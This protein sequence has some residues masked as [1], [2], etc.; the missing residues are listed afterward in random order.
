MRRILH[1]DQKANA[2]PQRRGPAGSFP[3]TV[4]FEKRTWTDVEPGKYLFSDYEVSKKVMYLLRHS[5]HVHREDDGA[6]QFWRIKE[7]LQKYYP[8]C[9]HWSDSKW[10]KRM[11][12]GGGNKKRYQYCTDS[13]GTI[14]YLRAL[15]RHSGSNLID[16]TLQDNV[17]FQSNFCHYIY[18]VGCAIN[19][20]SIIN[21]GLILGG[22]NLNN[23][24]TVFFLPVDPR[25][26]SHKDP[27]TIDL[28]EPR[29]AHIHA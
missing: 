20:H 4:P 28:N 14:V 17:V 22:Q 24:Q 25:D 16:P 18:H 11:A 10:K 12:G 19:L 2:K 7:I 13:S 1:A 3:R 21:S 15:Q 27:D 23:G 26:K 5:Q 6:V 9:P 29:H 8:Y